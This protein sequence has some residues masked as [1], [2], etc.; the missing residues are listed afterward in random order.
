MKKNGVKGFSLLNKN[1]SYTVRT[2]KQKFIVFL[3]R[4]GK[5]KNKENCET[6]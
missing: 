4:T 2:M 3:L 1:V 5:I 6:K